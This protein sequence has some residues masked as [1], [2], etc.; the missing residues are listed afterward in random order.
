M[1]L[2]RLLRSPCF[3][4]VHQP[5][6]GPPPGHRN[7][8]T[9]VL[10]ISGKSRRTLHLLEL[11]LMPDPRLHASGCVLANALGSIIRL[12]QGQSGLIECSFVESW[13]TELREAM[14][15]AGGGFL[16]GN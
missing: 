6:N 1:A 10:L 4:E 15:V 7:D 13:R 5:G 3:R 12:Q 2:V 9:Q 8:A 11:R 16:D 14:L